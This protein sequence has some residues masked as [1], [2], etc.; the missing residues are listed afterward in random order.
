MRFLIYFMLALFLFSYRVSDAA[1]KKIKNLIYISL[2][3]V[4]RNTLYELIRKKRLKGIQRVIQRGNYRNMQS[5]GG[6]LFQRYAVMLTGTSRVSIYPFDWFQPLMSQEGLFSTLKTHVPGIQTACLLPRLPLGMDLASLDLLIKFNQGMID[7]IVMPENRSVATVTEEVVRFF[8]GLE[9]P[10]MAFLSLPNALAVGTRFRE[11]AEVYSDTIIKLDRLILRISSQ[12]KQ[13]GLW[14]DTAVI[15]TTPVSLQSKSRHLSD[16]TWIASTFPVSRR[17]QL[18][19][20]VP[21]I[22]DYYGIDFSS[23]RLEGTRLWN[24]KNVTS[25]SPRD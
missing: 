18:V 1:E 16:Q 3:G 11:G 17:G 8:G 7:H 12:L 19:D 15:I 21:T 4:S 2:D 10:F 9:P 22:Y 13:R 14:E 23:L 25:V 5:S 20:I 24:I 6:G